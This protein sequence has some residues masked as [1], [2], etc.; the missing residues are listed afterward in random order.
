[1]CLSKNGHLDFTK[2]VR[3]HFV[4][5]KCDRPKKGTFETFTLPFPLF[6]LL[7]FRKKFRM[8]D[9]QKQCRNIFVESRLV[10]T[11]N[12]PENVVVVG[13]LLCKVRIS[14]VNS[15]RGT[16]PEVLVSGGNFW[17]Q[18]GTHLER[19]GVQW[20]NVRNPPYNFILVGSKSHEEDPF[21]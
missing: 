3:Y 16:R 21:P 15:L 14:T 1:M 10:F 18:P 4:S 8:N 9:Y 7:Y 11:L 5:F 2:S 19:Y 6:T 20:K 17:S 12:R 13:I